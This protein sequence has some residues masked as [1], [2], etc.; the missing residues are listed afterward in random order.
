MQIKP[1]T[2][3]RMTTKKKPANIAM[4]IFKEFVFSSGISY[5]RFILLKNTGTGSAHPSDA[6]TRFSPKIQ[7][8]K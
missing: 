8:P 3:T 7:H 2:T 1:E 5:F 6:C 4:H